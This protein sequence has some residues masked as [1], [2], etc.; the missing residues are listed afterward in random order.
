MYMY[1]VHVHVCYPCVLVQSC[2]HVHCASDS[3]FCVLIS[4]AV[5]C[6]KVCLFISPEGN[7]GSFLVRLSSVEH[8]ERHYS[9]SVK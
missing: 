6:M 5:I 4:F 2:I 1:I 3:A 9:L 8:S 7:V